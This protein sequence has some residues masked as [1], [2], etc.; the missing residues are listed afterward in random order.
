MYDAFKN[1]NTITDV[2][3][4]GTQSQFQSLYKGNYIPYYIYSAQN[5]HY[6]SSGPSTL[7]MASI[8]QAIDV[9]AYSIDWNESNVSAMVRSAL[10]I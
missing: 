7:V 5:I 2:Y 1:C 4:A 3:Y 6:N 9:S 8:E 10:A